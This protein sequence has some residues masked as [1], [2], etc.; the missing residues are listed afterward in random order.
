[1]PTVDT[2]IEAL[3]TNSATSSPVT[4]VS[5]VNSGGSSES[6]R[7]V[8]AVYKMQAT[9][10]SSGKELPAVYIKFERKPKMVMPEPPNE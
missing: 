4:P 8:C 7:E 5:P 9:R 3:R 1:M 6:L 10:L 2:N